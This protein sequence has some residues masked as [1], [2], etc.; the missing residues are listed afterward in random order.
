MSAVKTEII[1][2]DINGGTSSFDML[3]SFYFCNDIFTPYTSMNAIVS[4]D[5]IFD[6]QPTRVQLKLNNYLVHDGF[7]DTFKSYKRNGCCFF[8]V[9][10]KG[11]TALMTQN[12]L[13]PGLYSDIS[14][15]Q[16]M[17]DYISMPYVTHEDSSTTVNYIYVKEDKSFWDSV[18]NIGYKQN[19]TYPYITKANN[20]NISLPSEYSILMISGVSVVETGFAYDYRSIISDIYMQDASG[21]YDKYSAHCDLAD[22]LNIERRKE[23][24]L[25]TQ[26][27]YSPE[28]ALDYRIGLAVRKEKLQY[29]ECNAYFYADLYYKMEYTGVFSNMLIKKIEVRGNSKGI[30]TKYF[31]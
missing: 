22:S 11:F 24:P 27:L 15:N 29:V 10:S 14:F 1:I 26:Y 30:F 13:K 31:V 20:V 12:Y 19:G 6:K 3:C 16:L 4:C 25:D 5:S 18:E 9:T 17:D 7:I 8:S 2:Y 28:T 23:I 21:E